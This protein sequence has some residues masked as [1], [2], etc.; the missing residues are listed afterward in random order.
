MSHNNIVSQESNH[1][2]ILTTDNE[3]MNVHLPTRLCDDTPR[4]HVYVQCMWPYLNANLL[5]CAVS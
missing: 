1:I 5:H 3:T 2:L 4:I